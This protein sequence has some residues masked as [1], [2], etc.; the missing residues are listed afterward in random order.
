[1]GV[2]T[3]HAGVTAA[4]TDRCG[5]LGQVGE[6]TLTGETAGRYVAAWMCSASSRHRGLNSRALTR[7]AL[8]ACRSPQ[9]RRRLHLA[10]TT[11]RMRPVV[12]QPSVWPQAA[13]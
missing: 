4:G 13:R 10:A 3:H 11:R 5:T 1:M 2:K 12:S 6:H 7:D 9:A 8:A